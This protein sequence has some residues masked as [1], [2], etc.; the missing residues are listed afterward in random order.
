[1]PAA[2]AT[3]FQQNSESG[4]DG[5][6]DRNGRSNFDPKPGELDSRFFDRL[7]QP[8]RKL[9][10]VPQSVLELFNLCGQLAEIEIR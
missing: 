8:A 6:D 9:V 4:R 2:L 5:H 3:S 10:N 7:G 1:L